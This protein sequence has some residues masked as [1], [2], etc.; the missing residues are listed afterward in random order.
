ME[1]GDEVLF[2]VFLDLSLIALQD[3]LKFL[4]F[5]GTPV[6]IEGHTLL[7][8]C[9]LYHLDRFVLLVQLSKHFLLLGWTKDASLQYA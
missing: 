7:E 2:L 6:S 1:A 3:L 4:F 9:I 5:D 8:V